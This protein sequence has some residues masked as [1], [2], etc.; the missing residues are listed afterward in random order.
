ML[1]GGDLMPMMQQ[2]G[3]AITSEQRDLLLNDVLHQRP[4]GS[5]SGQSGQEDAEDKAAVLHDTA[6]TDSATITETEFRLIF[7][8]C[9]D[10][11]TME[12]SEGIKAKL[13][14]IMSRSKNPFIQ[15]LS[16]E[17]QRMLIDG[18]GPDGSP[19]CRFKTFEDGAVIVNQG[20]E[21]VCWWVRLCVCVCVCVWCGPRAHSCK[22]FISAYGRSILNRVS[23]TFVA[24]KVTRCLLLC[25]VS[26]RWW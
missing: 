26:S 13:L 1:S 15:M 2:L 9:L 7:K 14:L 25:T 16:N 8:T 21:G 12:P 17:E 20:D 6:I 10:N 23:Y 22:N 18:R 4:K 19:N 5:S 11:Q 24:A 3:L